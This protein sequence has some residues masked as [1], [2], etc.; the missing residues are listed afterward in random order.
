[1]KIACIVGARPNFMKMGPLIKA[2]AQ[3]PALEPV[4]I[5]TRAAL[6]RGYVQGVL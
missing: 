4:L 5:H 3:Y 6:R 1:M 2:M